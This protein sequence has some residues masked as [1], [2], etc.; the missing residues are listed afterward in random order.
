MKMAKKM[1]RGLPMICG[2]EMQEGSSKE[3]HEKRAVE[4]AIGELFSKKMRRP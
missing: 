2:D 3:E 1:C 4:L